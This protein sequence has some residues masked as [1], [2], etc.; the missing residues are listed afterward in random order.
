MLMAVSQ[1]VIQLVITM[2]ER[3]MNPFCMP[4]IQIPL[5]VNKIERNE[6]K[7]S[8]EWTNQEASVLAQ[9]ETIESER[10]DERL[11]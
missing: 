10:T 11:Q 9:P 8:E 5:C 7:W 1:L 3:Q 6:M 2:E 4:L